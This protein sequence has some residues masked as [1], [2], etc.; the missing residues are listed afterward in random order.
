[1]ALLEKLSSRKTLSDIFVT[2]LQLFFRPSPLHATPT[3][4]LGAAVVMPL[5]GNN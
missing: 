3:D 1:M 2:V 5:E 4:V